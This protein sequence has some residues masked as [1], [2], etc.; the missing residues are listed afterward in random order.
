MDLDVPVLGP[1]RPATDHK[2]APGK[3][4]SP[5]FGN[6]GVSA[7][8]SAFAAEVET[9][10]AIGESKLLPAKVAAY[11]AVSPARTARFG[12]GRLYSSFAQRHRRTP[13]FE[14]G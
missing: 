6:A 1:I 10:D 13:E 11:S 9:V 7:G 5:I 14:A 12:S 2:P 3:I 8:R 4:Q